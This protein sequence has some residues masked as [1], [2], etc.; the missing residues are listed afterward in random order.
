MAAED[1]AAAVQKEAVR[2]RNTDRRLMADYDAS[3]TEGERLR[4]AGDHAAALPR[5]EAAAAIAVKDSYEEARARYYVGLTRQERLDNQ[6]AAAAL[7]EALRLYQ[8]LPGEEPKT[9]AIVGATYGISLLRVFRFAEAIQ[10]FELVKTIRAG[11]PENGAYAGLLHNLAIAH[12]RGGN[13]ALGVD[14]ATRAVALHTKL[15]GMGDPSTIESKLVEAFAR[16]EMG[17]LDATAALIRD[18]ARVIRN[19]AGELHEFYG[20]ALLVEARR[21]ARKGDGVAAD[22]L[23]RRASYIYAQCKALAMDH[24]NHDLAEIR[25]LWKTGTKARDENDVALWR[26]SLQHTLRRYQLETLDFAGSGDRPKEWLFLVPAHWPLSQAGYAARLAFAACNALL[27]SRQPDDANFLDATA[28]TATV[29]TAASLDPAAMF[30]ARSWE[31]TIAYSLLDGDRA[32][33]LSP[34]QLTS[35]LTALP[36]RAQGA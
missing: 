13:P 23:T 32:D 21:V 29:V 30:A 24:R 1:L 11:M 15:D 22:A 34:A 14:Y 4:H 26:M 31:S 10:V 28:A 8:K 12:S 5:F 20:D 7:E 33:P 19:G 35:A 9:I 6:G 25:R 27:S 16:I 17:E 2:R 3:M 36:P 18:A